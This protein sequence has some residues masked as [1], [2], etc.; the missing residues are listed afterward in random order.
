MAAW[1]IGGLVAGKVLAKVG[2]FA[3]LLK[4]W[5]LIVIGLTAFGGVI[6][7][8]FSGRKKDDSDNKGEDNLI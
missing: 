4:S 3:L 2:F 7:R 6:W 8:F 5:K 1:T